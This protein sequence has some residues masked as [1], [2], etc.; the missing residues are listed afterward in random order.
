MSDLKKTGTLTRPKKSIFIATETRTGSNYLCAMMAETNQMGKP[1]EYFSKYV[2]FGDADTAQERY[3][4]ACNNSISPNGVISVKI[5][6]QHWELIE[7]NFDNESHFP[8]RK[9]IW[10]R[11]KD[12]ISQAISRCIALQTKA[13]LSSVEPLQTP[14]YSSSE[15]VKK[16]RFIAI[17]EARWHMFFARNDITPLVIW[18][19]DM[20]TEPEEAILNIAKFVDIDIDPDLINHDVHT[21]LQRTSLNEEWKKRFLVEMAD[22]NYM[23][24]LLPVKRYAFSFKTM[25]R[26]CTGKLLKP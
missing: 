13:W 18:Y 10:L 22:I 16:L 25:W 11:R 4:Y 14:V 21:R 7:R 20:I 12:L 8:D 23:D 19:E 26:L 9:W 17:S 5:F 1:G 3:I 6:P 24:K 15:I 2:R